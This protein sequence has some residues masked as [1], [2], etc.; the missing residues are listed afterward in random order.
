MPW[1]R[2]ADTSSTAII[3]SAS[4]AES[5]KDLLATG[6]FKASVCNEAQLAAVDQTRPDLVVIGEGTTFPPAARRALSEY[7][8]RRGNLVLLSPKAF[9]YL[10]K[11]GDNRTTSAFEPLGNIRKV[12]AK[13]KLPFK[14]DDIT[15]RPVSIPGL[16]GAA[17]EITT[18]L[19]GMAD[20]HVE[21][22]LDRLD[23]DRSLIC[24]W[25]KGDYEMDVL[26]VKVADSAGVEWVGFQELGRDWAYYQVPMAD[27][28]RTNVPGGGS[29][30]TLD[31]ARARTLLLGLNRSMVWYDKPGSFAVGRVS[32]ERREN[33]AGV[34]TSDLRRW[35]VCLEI[36]K[37]AFPEW[38]VD[39]F[40]D[41]EQ[42]NDIAR[43]SMPPNPVHTGRFDKPP[44]SSA[45]LVPGY[46]LR[47]KSDARTGDK[48]T[49]D[50]F[51][52]DAMRRIPLIEAFDGSGKKLGP[53]AEVRIHSGGRYEGAGM[54]LF[55]LPVQD[56][57][58]SSSMGRLLIAAAKYLVENPRII[59]YVPYGGSLT[60][61]PGLLRCDLAV[62]NPRNTRA[63]G[64]ITVSLAG[65][66]QARTNALLAPNALR[67]FSMII[68]E[69]PEDFPMK[70]FEW[71]IEFA[72]GPGKDTWKDVADVERAAINN[73]VHMLKLSKTHRDGRMSHHFFAD[74]YSARMMH[75]LGIYLQ[76]NPA[77]VERNSDLLGMVKPADL[78]QAAR[79]FCDLLASVQDP[80]GSVPLG[81]SETDKVRWVADAGSMML[82][83]AQLST[84][85]DDARKQ[86]YL[87]VARKYYD[88]K[89]TFYISEEKSA[90]LQ[91]IYGQG[92]PWTRPG[93][94]GLGL[95][96]Y[97]MVTREHWGER[98]RAE[99]GPDYVLGIVLG[100]NGI[101][102]KLDDKPEYRQIMLRDAKRFL[103]G[104]Y[105]AASYFQA[106]GAF[107]MHY[108]LEDPKLKA[109]FAKVL[110]T[111]FLP[112]VVNNDKHDWFTKGGRET[113]LW[114]TLVSYQQHI[115]NSPRVRA[116]LA[117]AVWEHC[118]PS[119]AFSVFTAAER[120]SHSSHGNS[121]AVAKYAGGCS[122]MW[123][124]EL[125]KPDST[126][127]K[128]PVAQP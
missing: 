41:T 26:S 23:K 72:S 85:Q 32:I 93:T 27:L 9:E 123:F 22:P 29:E 91:R 39:P 75:A 117:K 48:Q 63:Q 19:L 6:G 114:L 45:F 51:R 38:I 64:T 107:W 104:N 35:R 88:W 52:R 18:P 2:A 40:L 98:R 74:I 111:S 86:K 110:E 125:I 106:E 60:Q 15:S 46:N 87:D 103:D 49:A 10:P 36:A 81:Y 89:N 54:A 73:S 124:M 62:Q 76:A 99:R 8:A 80:D 126:L 3:Y 101:L 127:L 47:A 121:I 53:V 42:F 96:S 68:G 7:L 61:A 79:A 1:A 92:A 95:M 70:R 105:S 97:D 100:V 4:N 33:F 14:S 83:M 24:F 94:Y 59:E 82:G 71:S 65:R 28:I 5:L 77:S 34:P 17:A 37:A 31:P 20:I 113:L 13:K 44:V 55:G 120:F 69:I 67:R 118:S 16:A 109:V 43:L 84:W 112:S 57:S 56:Y 128:T 122:G 11:S 66:V 30:G 21:V 116:A 12:P 119:S 58:A 90:E 102:A 108:L 50:E 25:A 115:E 78:T